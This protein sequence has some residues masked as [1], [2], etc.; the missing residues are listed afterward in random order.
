MGSPGPT[1]GLPRCRGVWV[2]GV[3][4][5]HLHWRSRHPSGWYWSG[6]WWRRDRVLRDNQRWASQSRGRGLDRWRFRADGPTGHRLRRASPEAEG[7]PPYDDR[8]QGDGQGDRQQRRRR[9]FLGG[10][11]GRDLRWWARWGSWRDARSCRRGRRRSR[12]RSRGQLGRRRWADDEILGPVEAQEIGSRRAGGDRQRH[13]YR[14]QGDY[15]HYRPSQSSH[16][17]APVNHGELGATAPLRVIKRPLRF[18]TS[19]AHGAPVGLVGIGSSP[20]STHTV[21]P[22]VP[23]ARA[24]PRPASL[25]TRRAGAMCV[26]F[27]KRAACPVLRP[28]RC[29]PVAL[30]PGSRTAIASRSP[31]G[32]PGQHHT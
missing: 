22:L 1:D 29:G 8:H 25:W 24:T 23:G 26:A 7:Q 10:M 18:G 17:A 9:A 14:S 20:I 12:R 21:E 13:G 2:S 31:G 15:A 4:V 28:A 16:G 6:R 32:Y 30:S 5:S 3:L 27:R 19:T 11:R